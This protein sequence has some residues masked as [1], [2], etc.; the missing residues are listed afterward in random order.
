[1]SQVALIV[2]VIED[3]QRISYR[4]AF[5]GNHFVIRDHIVG[6]NRSMFFPDEVFTET[7]VAQAALF[8][9]A[10]FKLP[11]TAAAIPVKPTEDGMAYVTNF[12]NG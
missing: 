10:A 5:V 4:V 2:T 9:Q 1:M 3:R 11:V 12:I 7:D 6:P 8:A